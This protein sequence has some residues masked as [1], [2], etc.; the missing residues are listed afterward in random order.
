MHMH[1]YIQGWC[2]TKLLMSDTEAVFVESRV[3]FHLLGLIG[4]RHMT[5]T[6]ALEM[7]AWLNILVVSMCP[8]CYI[9]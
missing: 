9:F 7:N 1:V 5:C 6:L 2:V 3:T 8:L 4:S